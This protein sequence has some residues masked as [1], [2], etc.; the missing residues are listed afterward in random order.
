[1]HLEVL[2]AENVSVHPTTQPKHQYSNQDPSKSQIDSR[3][4]NTL[5]LDN[6]KRLDVLASLPVAPLFRGVLRDQLGDEIM[7]GHGGRDAG[8]PR[9]DEAVARDGVGDGRAAVRED[10]RV[11]AVRGEV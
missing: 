4:R 7:S 9:V 11:D 5:R 2:P 3:E 8:A 1:M 6:V 10:G